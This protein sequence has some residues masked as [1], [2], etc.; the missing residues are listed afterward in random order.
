MASMAHGRHYCQGLGSSSLR[1]PVC[2][3]GRVIFLRNP[4]AQ[5]QVVRL[6]EKLLYPLD[7]LIGPVLF[8]ERVPCILV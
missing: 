5:M 6:G 2:V 4:E 7:Y 3:D 8:F 1:P